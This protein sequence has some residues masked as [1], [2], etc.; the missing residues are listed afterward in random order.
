MLKVSIHFMETAQLVEFE[1]VVN[2]YTKG[3]LYCLDM[4]TN[5]DSTV[6]YVLK[7][8]LCNIFQIMEESAR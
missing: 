8:P 1:N 5:K 3:G 6:I 4:S 2:A 7:F